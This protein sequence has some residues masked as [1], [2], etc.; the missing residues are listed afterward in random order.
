M[1]ILLFDCFGLQ[2][3]PHPHQHGN[4]ELLPKMGQQALVGAKGG[5][6]NRTSCGLSLCW[7]LILLGSAGLTYDPAMRP[8]TPVALGPLML[9]ALHL[10]IAVLLLRPTQTSSKQPRPRPGTTLLISFSAVLATPKVVP[11]ALPT[12]RCRLALG[13]P[14]T[15]ETNQD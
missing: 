11:R 10:I 2:H 7:W 13:P 6:K 3:T 15:G 5:V 9:V 1:G 4:L 8:V 12:P 14:P